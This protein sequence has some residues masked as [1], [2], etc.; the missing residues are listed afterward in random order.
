[1][2]DPRERIRAILF[3]RLAFNALVLVVGGDATAQTVL[4]R[5]DVRAPKWEE[6]HGRYIISSNFEVDPRMSAVV[7]P[8]EPLQKDDIVNVKLMHMSAVHGVTLFQPG[9]SSTSIV[10]NCSTVV[11]PVA[12]A[13]L[14]QRTCP[15]P[16]ALK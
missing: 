16:A 15:E 10:T 1:M 6:R 5:V 3:T 7:Y 9:S 11:V 13:G 12:S 14:N 4:P 2:T 8:A